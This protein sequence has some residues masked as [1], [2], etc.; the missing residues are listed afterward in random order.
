MKKEQLLTPMK[1]S[2]KTAIPEHS[3]NEMLLSSWLRL[4]TSIHNSRMVSE[5]S[6]NESLICNLLYR[7]HV[8][9]N[10]PP[11]T[12]TGLCNITKMLKSQ[13]NR[14]LNQLEEKGMI[15]RERSDSDK[16]QIHIFLNLEQA[17][18]YEKQHEKILQ[19]LDCIIGEL[20]M[21]QAKDAILLFEKLSDIADRLLTAKGGTYDQNFS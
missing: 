16:R 3:I 7:H 20:G 19:L 6:Y 5:M 15:S 13:M 9:G 2:A 10:Q 18:S 14:T 8:N 11:L 12:A 4:S 17:K 21:E 1:L